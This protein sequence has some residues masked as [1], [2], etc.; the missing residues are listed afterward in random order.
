VTGNQGSVPERGPERWPPLP[1]KAAGAQ[2]A[3]SR[4]EEAVTRNSNASPAMGRQLE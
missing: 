1:R 3:Q 4:F 2:I